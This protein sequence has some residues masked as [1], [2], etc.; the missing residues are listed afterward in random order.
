MWWNIIAYHM[1]LNKI[2]WLSRIYE[3][4]SKVTYCKEKDVILKE[5]LKEY[6][7]K[8]AVT[9]K[10]YASERESYNA[11]RIRQCNINSSNQKKKG[12]FFYM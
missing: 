6:S 5:Q 1:L 12:V 11:L 9:K 3:V 8:L 10:R 2:L 7:E 4:T